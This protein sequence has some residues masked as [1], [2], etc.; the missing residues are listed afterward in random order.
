MNAK[1]TLT[2]RAWS[3]IVRNPGACTSRCVT[4]AR[5]IQ[6]PVEVRPAQCLTWQSS[7]SVYSGLVAEIGAWRVHGLVKVIVGNARALPE[8]GNGNDNGLGLGIGFF[9]G[10]SRLRTEVH[11]VRAGWLGLA[12]LLR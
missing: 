4:E 9:Q 6:M 7:G 11:G 3:G 10:Q 8:S 5:A 12:N 2:G 1:G